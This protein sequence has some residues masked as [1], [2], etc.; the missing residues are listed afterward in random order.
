MTRNEEHKK[1]NIKVI[2]G[3][4]WNRIIKKILST[5][6]S[7]LLS[8]CPALVVVSIGMQSV[9]R[10]TAKEYILDKLTKAN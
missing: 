9:L 4:I 8:C 5:I 7:G 6:P 2:F 1:N 3:E 10:P